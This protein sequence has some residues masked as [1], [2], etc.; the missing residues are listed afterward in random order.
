VCEMKLRT[1]VPYM[2]CTFIYAINQA[3]S[4]GFS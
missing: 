2:Y 3:F 1:T 4:I